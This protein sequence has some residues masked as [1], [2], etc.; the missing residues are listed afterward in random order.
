MQGLS[1]SSVKG[2]G[3]LPCPGGGLAVTGGEKESK[4]EM[5]TCRQG[6]PQGGHTGPAGLLGLP[7]GGLLPGAQ[8]S[9]RLILGFGSGQ[10]GDFLPVTSLYK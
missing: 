2:A 3:R 8:G 5:D 1:N 4:Q 6:S 9:G 10:G 7:G